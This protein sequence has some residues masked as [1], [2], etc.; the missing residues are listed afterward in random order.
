MDFFRFLNPITGKETWNWWF[1]WFISFMFIVV[2]SIIS[3]NKNNIGVEQETILMKRNFKNFNPIALLGLVGFFGIIGPIIGK[4]TWFFLLSWFVWFSFYRTTADERFRKNLFKAGL[5]S[6]AIT[7][8]GLISLFFM[9]DLGI[10]KDIIYSGI[11]FAY[12]I[13]FL[14]FPLVLKYFEVYGE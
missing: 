9:K 11:E 3:R 1:F 12:T 8:L 13:G 7:M 10:Y 6:Y 5:P 2:S 4:M 14:S